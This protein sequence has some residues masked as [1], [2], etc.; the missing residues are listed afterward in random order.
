M[1]QM[2]YIE[3]GG[4][5]VP[6]WCDIYVIA[7]V[8]EHFGSIWKFERKLLGVEEDAPVGK[9]KITKEPSLKALLYVLPLM[10]REGN[11]KQRLEGSIRDDELSAEEILREMSNC[12][13]VVNTV[14]KAFK[15]CLKAKK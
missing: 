5:Q 1:D 14:H 2:E 15:R 6:I 11:K 4:K 3:V 8:Q 7:E 9:A 10:I 13:G 12:W